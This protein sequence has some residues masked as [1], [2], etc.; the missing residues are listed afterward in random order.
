MYQ[1]TNDNQHIS[2]KFDL[3]L[4][5]VMIAF[6]VF[7]RQITNFISSLPGGGI[8]N[9]LVLFALIAGCYIIYRKRL[10]SYRYTIYFEQPKEGEP[11]AFGNVQTTQPYPLGTM[12]FERMI[13]NKGRLYEAVR[14]DEFV[15]LI[16]PG[17]TYSEK[18]N[19][20]NY[21]KLTVYS[22][23]TAYTLVFR[24]KDKL[25]GIYFHPD[26]KFIDCMRRSPLPMPDHIEGNVQDA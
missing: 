5:I 3:V 21:A 8:L 13:A 25:Y 20:L 24:R 22:N 2:A 19:L 9:V 4:V 12:L 17:E 14:Y 15:A 11:D 26:A 6:I 23:K 10:C 7:M 1:H 16:V 18:I